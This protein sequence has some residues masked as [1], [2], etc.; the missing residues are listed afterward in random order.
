M[1][2]ETGNLCR[3][4]NA[5]VWDDLRNVPVVRIQRESAS[6]LMTSSVKLRP[7]WLATS[8]RTRFRFSNALP[9]FSSNDLCN[10]LI[11]T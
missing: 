5:K 11:S 8:K 9:C 7:I 6:D 10:T 4:T 2:I 3:C 1:E